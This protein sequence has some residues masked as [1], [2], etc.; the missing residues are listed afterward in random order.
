MKKAVVATTTARGRAVSSSRMTAVQSV[1]IPGLG[2]VCPSSQ[3][4]GPCRRC[5]CRP[6]SQ[7]GVWRHGYDLS[8]TLCP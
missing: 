8:G 1:Y 7:A 5:S 2:V 3:P 6:T 4:P